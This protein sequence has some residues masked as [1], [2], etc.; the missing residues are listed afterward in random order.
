MRQK[1]VLF[2]VLALG[3]LAIA[4]SFPLQI[5]WLYQYE[6]FEPAHVGAIWNKLPANNILTMLILTVTAWKIWHVQPNL[7][8]W[9]T[10][11]CCAVAINNILV[12]L[13]SSDWNY[14]QTMAATVV[15]TLGICGFVFT[16]I[17][18]LTMAP[19]KHWWRVAKRRTVSIPVQV[20][21]LDHHR[22]QAQ[23]FD[24][25]ASGVFLTDI[26]KILPA[27]MAPINEEMAIKIPYRNSFHAFRVKLVRKT[28]PNG[29]YPE[30]WGLTFTNLDLWQRIKLSMMMRTSHRAFT[31]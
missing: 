8:V 30:G 22:F 6:I 3:L 5:A 17:Y 24:M 13:N 7:I 16:H 10:A 2:N 28:P 25:S 14:V 15:F 27:S 18:D 23:V 19:Q 11:S 26:N 1:P 4:A 31:C 21:F 29:K 12:V 20:E 9:I